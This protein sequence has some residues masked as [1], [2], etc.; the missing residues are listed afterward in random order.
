M[1]HCFFV[2]ASRRWVS[3]FIRFGLFGFWEYA[4]IRERIGE[5]GEKRLRGN[6][7]GLKAW[8]IYQKKKEIASREFEFWCKTQRA[9]PAF[10]DLETQP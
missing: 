5:F 4:E 1:D 8:G 3:E 2:F 6:F 7:R 9:G 10:L